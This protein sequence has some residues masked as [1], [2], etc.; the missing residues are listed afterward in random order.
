MSKKLLIDIYGGGFKIKGPLLEYAMTNNINFNTF[1]NSNRDDPVAIDIVEKYGSFEC[2][3][4]HSKI[5]VVEIPDNA[6][7][8]MISDNYNGREE[9][10]YVLDGKICII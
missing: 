5:K 9:V 3:D 1:G 2:S 7:D 10:I 8:Y 4:K 6:S